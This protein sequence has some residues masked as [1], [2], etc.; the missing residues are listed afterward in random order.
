MEL[1]VQN[2]EHGLYSVE[3][4]LQIVGN[5]AQSKEYIVMCIRCRVQKK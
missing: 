2:I 1:G 4:G 5:R 3:Y